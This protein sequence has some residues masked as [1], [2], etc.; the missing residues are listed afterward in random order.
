M[1][2]A[3]A[4]RLAVLALVSGLSACG[5]GGG[6]ADTCIG[7]PPDSGTPTATGAALTLTVSSPT[8]TTDGVGRVTVRATVK[9]ASN[10]AVPDQTVTFSA[11]S[12]TLSAAAATTSADGV[13]EV[14][15]NTDDSKANRVATITARHGGLQ[16]T[17]TVTVLG[18]TLSFGG[19]LAAVINQPVSMTVALSDAGGASIQ[20][21][22]VTLKSALGNPVPASVTTN[23]QGQ[24]TFSFTP[25][26]GG[27]DSITATALG[28]SASQALS[29]SSVNFKFDSPTAGST[30][31]VSTAGGCQLVVLSL[32][33][34][35][36]TG[37][38]VTNPRGTVHS[39]SACATG[40]SSSLLVPLSSGTASAYVKAPSAGDS[41]LLATA[42]DGTTNASTTLLVK[43]IAL[44]PATIA[45]QGSPTTVGLGGSSNLSALVKDA[46]GNPVAGKTVTFT[47]PNGGGTPSPAQAIT[48]DAG[49]ASTVFKA[50]P[51]ISGKDSVT[52]VATVSGTTVT[53]Q[54]SLTV[55]G[56][57]VNVVLGT[58]N[59]I[60]TIEPV[61]YRKKFAAFV[62]DTAGNPVPNQTVT[63]A[64]N[65]L[66]FWKGNWTLIPDP[67][68][69]VKWQQNVNSPECVA[70]ES[71]NN[72]I[73][74]G[75]EPG[76][77][78]GNGVFEPNGS[79]LV[80]PPEGAQ[81]TT[82]VT[83]V[84]GAGGSAEFWLEFPRNYASWVEADIIATA[85]V[86]G[87]NSASRISLVL[88]FPASEITDDTVAPPFVRS[89]F[90]LGSS[91]FDTL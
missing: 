80:R 37:V 73:I 84:T 87:R 57:A 64:L 49:R 89:P 47:A 41:T 39:D 70:E 65:Y 48:D 32:S 55:S 20:N 16:K 15:F 25:T 91:C 83:I 77:L 30:I 5:G 52:V 33:G 71:N 21:T 18:T 10:A 1:L 22:A 61:S 79:A 2:R 36:A 35:G 3:I 14:E 45:V 60:E 75:T 56:N 58:D 90:G 6:G 82:S 81:N 26:A 12:G 46:S 67:P 63:V 19:D 17:N 74:D 85:V 31:P 11:D 88:P 50:D 59:L 86:A 29:I 34:F 43:F 28:A 53:G 69:A 72:G 13:A 54:T 24:G 27:S 51:S 40:S 9:D 44:T 78:N 23:A 38:T 4:S 66:G 68:T 42:T 76:D 7:C 62:T 8:L